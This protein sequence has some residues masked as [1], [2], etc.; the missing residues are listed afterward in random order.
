MKIQMLLGEA[1]VP[2][3]VTEAKESYLSHMPDFRCRQVRRRSASCSF[4]T[5]VVLLLES[6]TQCLSMRWQVRRVGR[7]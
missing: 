1:D 3:P 4:P 6:A 5:F 7:R 2:P